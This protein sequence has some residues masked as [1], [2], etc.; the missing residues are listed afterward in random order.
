MFECAITPLMLSRDE[1]EQ[2][3]RIEPEGWKRL[4]EARIRGLSLETNEQAATLMKEMAASLIALT[5]EF[6]D[7][8]ENIRG[9]IPKADEVIEKWNNWK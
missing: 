4:N 1:I 7:E 6:R 3:M 8:F 9:I 5:E 2:L